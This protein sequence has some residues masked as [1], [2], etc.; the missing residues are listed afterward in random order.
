MPLTFKVISHACLDVEAKGQHLLIDPW[1]IGSCYWSSWWHFPSEPPPPA[2]LPKA[3]W[4]YLSHQHPDHCHYPTL[5]SLDRNVTILVPRFANPAMRES[6]DG[7]G[8]RQVVELP[9]G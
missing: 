9:H 4:V 7:L 8:F 6:L 3:E 2:E 1:L 5:R